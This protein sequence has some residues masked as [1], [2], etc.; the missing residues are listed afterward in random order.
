MLGFVFPSETFCLQSF[1]VR[2]EGFINLFSRS[3]VLL[4]VPTGLLFF[5]HTLFFGGLLL[6]FV[7]VFHN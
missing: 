3:E 6:V 7:N 1:E 4:R 2:A 5:S